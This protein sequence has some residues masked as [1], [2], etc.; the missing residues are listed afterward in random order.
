MLIRISSGIV[1]IEGAIFGYPP[2]RAVA[3]RTS[4]DIQPQCQSGK[5]VERKIARYILNQAEK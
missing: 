3:K 2:S 5:Y 1:K 4:T